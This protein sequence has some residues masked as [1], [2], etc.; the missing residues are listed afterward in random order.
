MAF[1]ARIMAKWFATV[2]NDTIA[3]WQKVDQDVDNPDRDAAYHSVDE[4]RMELF[5]KLPTCSW[6][7]PVSSE[8][9]NWTKQDKM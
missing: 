4:A 9:W 2:H 6:A 8:Q 1:N 5:K 3:L 7:L